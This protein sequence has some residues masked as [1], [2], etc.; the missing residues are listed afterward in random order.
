[1]GRDLPRSEIAMRII[2]CSL[3]A[4]HDGDKAVVYGLIRNMLQEG[5]IHYLPRCA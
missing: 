1:M 2:W 3:S 5:G 4:K